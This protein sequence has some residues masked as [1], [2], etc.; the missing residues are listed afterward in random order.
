VGVGDWGTLGQGRVERGSNCVR[1]LLDN[2]IF[3]HAEF[4]EGTV[5]RT[6]VRRGGSDQT[7]EVHG[8]ARKVPSVDVDYQRQKEALFTVGRLIRE[9]RIEAFDYWE[10]RCEKFRGTPTVKECNALRDCEIRS[11]DPAIK[12]S[13]FRQSIDLTDVFS[14]GGKKDIKNGIELGQANQ[15]A[16]FEWLCTL[17]GPE[18]DL[19]VSHAALLRLTPFEIDSLRDIDRFQ[20]L[21]SRSGSRENYPDV[22]HLWTA[23]R[24][25]LDALLTLDCGLPALASRVKNEKGKTVK[26]KT[27]V[28]QP[29]DLL[30]RLGINKPDP[31][32]MDIG[33]FYYLHE[34]T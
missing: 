25:G 3:I 29:I 13:M 28:L 6:T 8:L 7:F 15:I 32:P 22:F 23:E 31:V 21:C 1:V 11:C 14:K 2:G 4:A 9:G 18:V 10:I 12:R 33:R 27:E 5:R 17:K 30:R 24:N 20:F 16:F 34:L 19:L 26:M